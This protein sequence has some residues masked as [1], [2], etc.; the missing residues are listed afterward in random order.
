[1]KKRDKTRQGRV[2]RHSEYSL[3][4]G[5]IRLKDLCNQA[6]DFGMPAAAITDHGNLYGAISFYKQAKKV[7]IKPIIGC[8]VYV[9]PD[10]QDRSPERGRER[11]HLVLLAQNLLGYHNLAKIVSRGALFGFHYRPRVDKEIL[12]KH[13]EGIIALSACIAGEV[14]KAILGKGMDEARRQVLEYRSIFPDRFFLEL[15]VNGLA[16]Q[17]RVNDGLLELAEATSTPLVATND[18]H[19]LRRDDYEA[20]DLLLCIQTQSV[21]S[22]EK[23]MR[24]ETKE[25]YYKSTEEMEK[26]FAWA[27]AEAL[28]NTMRIGLEMCQDY[29][30]EFGKAHFPVYPVPEG[31]T[32]DD[33]FRRL[34]REGLAKRLEKLSYPADEKAYADRLKME[35]DVIANM[36]YQGY[37]LIVQDFIN[38]AKNNDIPVGPGRGSAAGSLVAWALRITNLDPLPY[39]LLF[40]RFLNPER[41]SLPDIDV[42]FCERNRHKVLEYVSER[43]GADSVSQITTF[44]TMKAKA[45]V[46][47]VGR[48]LGMTFKETDRIAKL[49]PEDLKMTI[50]KALDAEPELKTLYDTDPQITKLIDISRRL[51]GMSRH[52]STHAAGVVISDRPMVDYLPLYRG[53]KNEVVTQYDKNIVEEVGLVKFD[54][55]GLKTMTLL[56]D[57][58]ENIRRQ[59]KEVPDLDTLPLD[60]PA[61]YKLYSAG[62]TDGIFQVESSGMRGYLRQLRPTVFEDIIAMLALYRPGPLGANMVSSFIDR[63]HGVEEITYPLDSLRECLQDTYGVIVYQE[64]VMQIAQIVAGY[65]L[66]GADM[67]RRAMGKKDAEKMA[68]ERAKFVEGAKKGGVGEKE[69]EAV[70]SLMEKFAEYGFNK[71]HS[72]AYALISYHTAYLK[73]HYKPEFMAAL[74]TSEMGNQDKLLKY[75]ASCKDAGIPVLPPSVQESEWNFSVSSGRI[76]FG[77]GGIKNVGGEAIREIVEARKQGG[78]FESLLDLC[79]RVNLRKVTK[80]VLENLIKGGAFDCLGCTRGALSASL[81]LAVAR[82]QKKQKDADSGQNS[83]LTLL[84]PEKK[85]PGIGIDCPEASLPEWPEDV[86]LSNEKDALGF[87]LTS[88]PLQPYLRDMRRIGAIPLEDVFDFAGREELKFGVLVNSMRELMTKKGD[89]MAFVQLGDLS[90][91]AECVFFPEAYARCRELLKSEQP[92]ELTARLQREPGDNGRGDNGRGGNEGRAPAPEAPHEAVVEADDEEENAKREIKLQAIS[93][94]PLLEAVRGSREPLDIEITADHFKP[95]HIPSLKGLLQSYKG[96]VEVNLI[97][98]GENY[99][100]RLALPEEY[101]VMPGPDLGAALAAWEKDVLR[102]IPA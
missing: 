67:L 92:L 78:P 37:F 80:R 11:Y 14:P 86:R 53:K 98:T 13:S 88:H 43:Y 5:A 68:A 22:D 97:L 29:N 52:A 3:L 49:I 93:V 9:C 44:G 25:L 102:S 56:E 87:F 6:V 64:Q 91:G 18:C 19:Y 42:D 95:G 31:L 24:F 71:S 38:W 7:G 47:D 63:K 23:R 90:A 54:F 60:D 96:S 17:K 12:R 32:L 79:C 57:T 34:A 100:C 10:H 30:F 76:L 65:T 46:R 28:A 99:W 2:F 8:E 48:A 89:R 77:L 94:R 45:V 84:G 35:L 66:G 58:L 83:L 26:D 15:Q 101:Q 75:V 16:E 59:G 85:L 4:D 69:A 36:G 81:E 62:D 55:L 21:V 70:F 82:A 72:A 33:E 74:M 40:E 50:D 39:N 51:E 61:V 1:M 41:V 27:P 73:A 20:H